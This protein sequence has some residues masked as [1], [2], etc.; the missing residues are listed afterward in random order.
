VAA[1]R[2]T[3]VLALGGRPGQAFEPSAWEEVFA[4]YGYRRLG[5]AARGNEVLRAHVERHPDAWQGQYHL[6]CFAALDGDREAALEHLARAVAL[7]PQA[8]TWAADDADLDLIRD[9]PRFPLP[10]RPAG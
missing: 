6:A 3:T 9:D 1:E 2:G 5:D 7:D 4:A 8:A 10:A